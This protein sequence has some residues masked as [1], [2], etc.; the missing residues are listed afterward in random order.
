M[1]TV[2]LFTR[3]NCPLCDEAKENLAAIQTEI[4]HR[5][6]EVYVDDNPDLFRQ[7]GDRVPVVEVGPYRKFS[8][9]TLQEL[10]VTLGAARDRQ[11]SLQRIDSRQYQEKVR[12]G[13]VIDGGDRFTWWISRNYLWVINIILFLYVGLPF[14]APVLMKSGLP[15]PAKAIYLVYSPFCHQLGFRSWFLFGEQTYYPR[16]AAKIAGV[17][18]F[19]E[20]TGLNEND[21]L[22]ARN[23]VGNNT[24]GYKVALCQR[25]VALY[26]GILIFSIIFAVSDRQIKPLPWWAWVL[27]GILPICLDG[28][29]QLISQLGISGLTSILPYRESTPFLR[30]LTGFLFGFTT[31]W[32]GIPYIE[33]SMRE[34]RAQ[35]VKKFAIVN[36]KNSEK[37]N[38]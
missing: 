35:L 29:S 10:T 22:A 37:N 14:L 3:K 16:V 1:I 17:K 4:A 19:G 25:D 13:Q 38:D 31:A 5:L 6:V 33:E 15:Q 8:P 2:T 18:T 34:S 24:V 12:R 30:T 21:L 7:Y 20:V 28:F 32:F 26:L 11:D 23:F 27:F 9:F 36:V